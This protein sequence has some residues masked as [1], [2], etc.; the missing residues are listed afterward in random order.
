MYNDSSILITGGTGTVG[1][2][3]TK[4]LLAAWNPKKIVIFSRNEVSQVLMKSRFNNDP[5]LEFMIGDVR[6]RSSVKNACKGIDYIFHLAALKHVGICEKQ[7]DEAI[8]TNIYGI[9]NIIKA[10]IAAGVKKVVNMST[11]KAVNPVSS[12][13]DT[14]AMGE[15]LVTC[16]GILSTSPDDTCFLNIRSGNVFGSSGSVVLLFVDQLKRNNEITITNGSMTRYFV[17]LRDI[18]DFLLRVMQRG[19][20]GKTYVMDER[21]SFRLR[22]LAEVIIELRGN[23]TSTI[24]EIGARSGEKI[25]EELYGAGEEGIFLLHPG[26]AESEP[27]TWTNSESHVIDKEQ[28]KKWINDNGNC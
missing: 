15:R 3:V 6:D 21:Q 5:R 12:Y 18:A 22:D 7:P 14:K 4:G 23:E 9:E 17:S 13:G 16:S 11:D 10:A 20:S 1:Q 2:E 19:G 26:R 28:L 25:H 8:K 24:K 27:M